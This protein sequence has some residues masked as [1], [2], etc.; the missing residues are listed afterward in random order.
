[1]EDCLFFR[2]QAEECRSRARK[3]S[4]PVLQETLRTLSDDCVAYA[5]K[6]DASLGD[7]TWFLSDDEWPVP[8]NQKV[9]ERTWSAQQALGFLLLLTVPSVATLTWIFL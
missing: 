2:K 7:E 1:M 8:K 5:N 9:A 4:D 3:S 6:I